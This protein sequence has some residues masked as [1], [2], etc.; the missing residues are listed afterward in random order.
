L[1][2]RLGHRRRAAED[3]A[4][5]DVEARLVPGAFDAVAL[6]R[7]LVERP[8]H[9]R[10]SVADRVE[11]SAALAQEDRLTLDLDFL[12]LVVGQPSE[13]GRPKVS[14]QSARPVAAAPTAPAMPTATEASAALR[15]PSESAAS[16]SVSRTIAAVHM[17]TGMST[18]AGCN[19]WPSQTPCKKF[20]TA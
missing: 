15:R 14:L 17:P 3:A 19:G 10:A 20:F 1:V 11:A 2:A 7:A 16:P 12:R 5:M 6:E 9:V 8:A 4:I 13:R 18:T